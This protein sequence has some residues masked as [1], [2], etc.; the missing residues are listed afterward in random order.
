M[1][2]LWY[3]QL[4]DN[5]Q[6]V[7]NR[8]DDGSDWG[9]APPRRSGVELPFLCAP[10]LAPSSRASSPGDGF[11]WAVTPRRRRS[12]T[13][14]LERESGEGDAPRRAGHG[15]SFFFLSNA[16][17]SVSPRGRVLPRRPRRLTPLTITD[18]PIDL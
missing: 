17:P 5:A 8:D 6:P 9:C 16:S 11:G 3:Q 10:E 14:P 15:P 2:T 18:V 12:R 13:G 1:T 4:L 7:D